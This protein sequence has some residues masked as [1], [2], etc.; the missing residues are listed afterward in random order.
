MFRQ[1]DIFH[2]LSDSWEDISFVI[3]FSFVLS[4]LPEVTQ[5]TFTSSKLTVET[6]EQSVK[7]VQS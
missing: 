1:V 6:Q 4:Y 3:S 2:F 7:H 5:P